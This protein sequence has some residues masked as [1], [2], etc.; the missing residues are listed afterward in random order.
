[1]RSILKFIILSLITILIPSLIMSI[2]YYLGLNNI[3]IIIGQLF[4]ILSFVFIFQLLFKKSRQYEKDTLK[5]IE[6]TRDI[7]EL[8]KLRDSRRTYRSKAKITHKILSIAYSDEELA[9]LKKYATDKEDMDHY[10]SALIDNAKGDERE[11]YKIRRDNFDKRY[12]KKLTIYPDFKGNLKT[13]L[14]WMAFFFALA[15]IY[16]LIPKYL[17]TDFAFAVFYIFGMAFLAIVMVNT[18][19]WIVRTLSSYWTKDYI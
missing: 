15:I 2:V 12:G 10:Y 14:K 3:G 11:S 1:M 4:V 6:K 16:N 19:L 5:M 18:I 9:N 17:T 8:K 7:D 13:S